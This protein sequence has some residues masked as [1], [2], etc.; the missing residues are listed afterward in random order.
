MTLCTVTLGKLTFR[1]NEMKFIN[2]KHN[3][4]QRND[5]LHIGTQPIEEHVL[6][7]SA[8]KELS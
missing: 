3:N 4:M 1:H 2:N 5:T 7:I 6:D 8:E